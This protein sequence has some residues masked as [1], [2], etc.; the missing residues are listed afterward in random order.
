MRGRICRVGRSAVEQQVGAG[1]LVGAM[2]LG[3][4]GDVVGSRLDP[5]G[6]HQLDRETV[7]VAQ[8][9]QVVPGRTGLE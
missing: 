1:G 4:R 7:A 8:G 9:R 5:G 6:I 2:G 3:L